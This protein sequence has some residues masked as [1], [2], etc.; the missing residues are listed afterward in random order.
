MGG[1]QLVESSEEGQ[2]LTFGVGAKWEKEPKSLGVLTSSETYFLLLIYSITR[3]QGYSCAPFP[4]ES[5]IPSP[6]IVNLGCF[7]GDPGK[8]RRELEACCN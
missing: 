4:A 6:S 1:L 8:G 5:W 7:L 2:T 3:E